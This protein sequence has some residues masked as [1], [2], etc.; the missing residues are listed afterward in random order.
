V[1]GRARKKILFTRVLTLSKLEIGCKEIR[2]MTQT[3]NGFL[4]D[5]AGRRIAADDLPSA[6][7]LT[8]ISGSDAVDRA[9][10]KAGFVFIASVGPALLV[11]LLPETVAPLAALAAMYEVEDSAPEHVILAQPTPSWVPEPF[12]FVTQT[13][14]ALQR[15]LVIACSASRRAALRVHA[16]SVTR[17]PVG[18]LP[19][20][21]ADAG[22]AIAE[23]VV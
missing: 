21:D 17:V 20:S 15:M 14:A 5:D 7:G 3:V 18:D 6:E 13:A 4:F 10:A 11:K 1:D 23:I 16:Q 2:H 8:L 22:R 9:V 19:R 12:E